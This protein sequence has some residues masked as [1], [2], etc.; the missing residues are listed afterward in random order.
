MVGLSPDII[1]F[2]LGNSGVL[3]HPG[4]NR[5]WVLNPVAALIWCLLPECI[6]EQDLVNRIRGLYGIDQERVGKDIAECLEYFER[7]GLLEGGRPVEEPRRN[8]LEMRLE[9]VAWQEPDSWAHE[10]FFKVP[11]AAVRFVSGD[12]ELGRRFAGFLQH[13]DAGRCLDRADA[14]IALAGE[15]GRE[16][17][18]V[19]LDKGRYAS[20]L[21]GDAVLPYLNFL[22]FYCATKGLD[23]HFLLHGAVLVK[24]GRALVLP[25]IAGSGKTT[26]A[27]MLAA[28]GW[29]FFSDELVVLDVA[30]GTVRPFPFPMSV[31]SGSVDVL[32]TR[33]P[34][35][36]E[37][38]VW[39]R[40]DGQQVRYLLPPAST[41]P[42]SLQEQAVPAALVFPRYQEGAGTRMQVMDK[43]RA[44]QEIAATGSSDRLL[45]PEDVSAMI[46]LVE[47]SRVYSLVF[48]DAEKAVDVLQDGLAE[49][50]DLG[51]LGV[52]S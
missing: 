30:E 34:E 31:K 39:N 28:E 25:G 42:P 40:K 24:N 41:L 2:I 43:V 29:H 51:D 50:S 21:P 4:V 26:L 10:S 1:F 45:R 37:A 36:A 9:P 15:K 14:V 38:R 44:I 17:W 19:F 23:E 5:L 27:A 3:F 35:L 8:S 49:I 48:D 52:R 46:L 16:G 47:R 12:K 7:E 33:Y 18:S 6:D 11:G 13:L 22:L 32:R 20:G